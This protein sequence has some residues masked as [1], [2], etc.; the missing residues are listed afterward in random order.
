[1]L[2]LQASFNDHD[3]IIYLLNLLVIAWG[4]KRKEI[5]T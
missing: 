2:S 1:M 3:Q 5:E 4:S